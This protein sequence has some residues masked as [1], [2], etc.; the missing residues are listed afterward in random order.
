M[1]EG[2]AALGHRAIS[3][4]TV[5]Y[6]FFWAVAVS[7]SD[8]ERGCISVCACTFAMCDNRMRRRTHWCHRSSTRRCVTL[9]TEQEPF[10]VTRVALHRLFCRTDEKECWRTG[11]TSHDLSWLQMERWMLHVGVCLVFVVTLVHKVI[12]PTADRSRNS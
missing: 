2:S 9:T 6:I 7:L 5:R 3:S 10:C 1:S 12:E 8:I 4:G 11:P